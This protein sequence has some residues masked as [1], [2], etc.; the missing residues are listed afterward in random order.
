[1]LS[2]SE[3]RVVQSSVVSVTV[4]EKA[5]QFIADNVQCGNICKGE[6]SIVGNLK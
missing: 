5:L 6:I 3:T 1:M 4:R 2:V